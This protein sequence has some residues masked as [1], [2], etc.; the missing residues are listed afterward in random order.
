MEKEYLLSLI[1]KVFK[2]DS[3]SGYTSNII[4][5]L[6]EECKKFNYQFEKTK[7]GNLIVTI[8]GKSDYVTGLS[9]HVDTLGLMVR[10]IKSDGCLTFT[11]IGGPI[12]PTFDGEY[13][14]VITRDGKVFTGTVLSNYPAVH[15]F[16]EASKAERNEETMHIRL[17]EITSS[18]ENTLAL[19]INTGDFICI[20]PKTTITEK[21]FVKS[22]FLDDKISVCILF[23]LL[24]Y[25][26]DQNIKP[27]NTIKIIISTYEEVG[28]GA[29][30][31]PYVD[32]LISV[33]M[34]CIGKDLNCTEYD[35]SICCKDSSGPYDF[36]LTNALITKAKENNISYAIDV[37]PYYSSDVSAALRGG[38][39]IKGALIGPGVCASHGMERTHLLGI[40]STFELLINYLK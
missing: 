26:H 9:A 17:D 24:K 40:T 20:D 30:Y 36:E 23:T 22:R 21:G 14:K 10:S 8:K 7:K 12:L 3:P 13:C 33:D 15:V 32:E 6:E 31:I 5:F 4:S 34:G 19:G 18:K 39:N 16:S 27:Q 25:Y 38:A 1:D 37:Y 28:H 2:I 29:S 11:K 35:V